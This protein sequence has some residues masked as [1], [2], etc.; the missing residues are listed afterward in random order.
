MDNSNLNQFLSNYLM[1]LL[2]RTRKEKNT[3]KI[4]FDWIIYNL[5]VN[6]DWQ[7]IRLPFLRQPEEK[8][9]KTKTEAEHGID[10][11]FLHP[12]RNCLVIFVLKDEHLTYKNWTAHG[13]DTD[14]RQAAYPDLSQDA[15]V[16]V[17]EVKVILAYNKDEDADGIQ[18][19]NNL[20][21]NLGTAIRD[22]VSLSFERWNLVKIADLVKSNLMTP[23]LLPQNLA[24]LLRY[25]CSQFKDFEYESSQWSD[26]LVPNWRN[27]LN[28]TLS[29]ELDE[30]KIRL[31]PVALFILLDFKKD[32]RGSE[33]GWISL[34]E[35]AM[36]SLWEK[37]LHLTNNKLK[38]LIEEIWKTFY[39]GQLEFYFKENIPLLTI[40]H[41]LQY[42][43][44]SAF[45]VS[46]IADANVAFWHLGRLGILTLGISDFIDSKTT[47]GQTAINN[48][49]TSSVNW[50]VTC[51]RNNPAANR[52]LIDLHHIEFF[53]V[54]FILWH[55]QKH[56]E[57]YVWLANLE[58]RLLVRKTGLSALP[59]IESRNRLDLVAEYAAKKEKPPEY[60]D[61]TSYLLLMILELCCAL[62]AE[63]REE[64]IGIYAR[65]LIKGLGDEGKEKSSDEIDLVGWAPP[66]DWGEH[67]LMEKVANGVAITGLDFCQDYQNPAEI[68]VLIKEF[69]NESR[70]KFPFKLPDD[71]PLAVAI[72]GCIKFGSPLPPE[73][74]RS[75][76][77]SYSAR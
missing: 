56:E 62:P 24:G 25:I 18:A 72:L 7:P 23:E 46:A 68:C 58:P 59:F 40:E 14:L 70:E 66:E 20:I 65:R 38:I 47:E 64:L 36:L 61:N 29:G 39:L 13:F 60:L 34:I 77:F 12:G 16:N 43:S 37:H 53:L 9:A 41:G 49:F 52:P 15:L 48:I 10:M 50:L 27:F 33:A 5:G 57:I 67:V 19:Y 17:K 31:I 42:H 69:I 63:F 11:S 51:L 54:W 73:Y 74:W 30:R 1:S 71:I 32:I 8:A 6:W 28:E 55:S 22:K 4:G 76:I 75:L 21:N 26:Q 2:E 35:W 3:L 45:S 44:T